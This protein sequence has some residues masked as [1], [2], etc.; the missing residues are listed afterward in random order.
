MWV[1]I[2]LLLLCLNLIAVAT[3]AKKRGFSLKNSP[4]R[5]TPKPCIV[6]SG[7]NSCL[8]KSCYKTKCLV[9]KI[10]IYRNYLFIN[11]LNFTNLYFRFTKT[12]SIKLCCCRNFFKKENF[13]KS[14]SRKKLLAS[15][16]L[17]CKVTLAKQ[18]FLDY[19]RQLSHN[20]SLDDNLTQM[21]SSKLI[22]IRET[23]CYLICL[24]NITF[25]K[26]V[27]FHFTKPLTTVTYK[28]VQK[29]LSRILACKYVIVLQTFNNCSL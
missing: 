18:G 20:E 5:I 25:F 8:R 28:Y 29:N 9:L 12:I 22:F 16:K 4:V 15:T 2:P 6:D 1:R 7:S 21:I 13:Y 23:N 26:Y 10:S 24:T 11:I 19:R 14:W 27:F 17:G 3:L